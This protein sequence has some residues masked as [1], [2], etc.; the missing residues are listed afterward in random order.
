MDT[1][2]IGAGLAGLSIANKLSEKGKVLVIDKL[3]HIG[4][5]CY[6]YTDENNIIVHKYGPHIFHTNNE[7]V[8]NYLSN[9]T[10]WN[11]YTHKVLASYNNQLVNFPFNL[12]TL[13]QIFKKEEADLY[14]KLISDEFELGSKISIFDLN[15]N[16]KLKELGSFIIN[17]FYAGYTK[18]QWGKD[19]IDLN[20][21]ILKR[22]PIVLSNDNRYFHDKFQGTPKLGYSEML[23]NM[24][25]NNII[26]DL[27]SNHS[28]YIKNDNIMFLNKKFKGNVIYTG[29]IDELFDYTYGKLPYRTLD[30]DF[31]VIDKEQFQPV[32][33]VNYSNTEKFTRITEF[34]H[35]HPVNTKY[36]TIL[37][38]YPRDAKE[39]DIKYYPVK[40]K[41]SQETLDKYLE[42]VKK[43]K[44]LYLLGRLGEFKYYNMDEVVANAINLSKIILNS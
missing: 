14:F 35:M 8:F 43:I 10:E 29:S 16:E 37:K 19:I 3:P 25:N 21:D 7:L 4:G 18:K 12:T 34:K 5:N 44:N 38:E 27:N 31:K 17:N 32:A 33:V 9:F 15:K 13:Y 23:N 41:H 26:L 1:I 22:V 24:I 30:L 2:V 11:N 36:T 39:L 6:D 40:N 20:E 28:I 42:K